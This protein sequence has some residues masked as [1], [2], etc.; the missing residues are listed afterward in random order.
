MPRAE[1]PYKVLGN[2]VA[3]VEALHALTTVDAVAD[4]LAQAAGAYGVE[5]FIATG[6]PMKGQ[7]FS[8]LVLSTRWPAAFFARYVGSHYARSDPLLRRS[9]Q[10]GLPFE[11]KADSYMPGHEV[12]RARAEHGLEH[13]Y[14]APIHHP[15]GYEGCVSMSGRALDLSVEAKLSLHILALY[16]FDRMRSLHP[17]L[18][19]DTPALTVRERE[20][21]SWMASGKSAA[22][23]SQSLK[24]SK[25]TVD[26]HSQSAARKLGAANR[27]QAV[28]MALRDGLIKV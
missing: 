8:D 9:I 5:H 21:L 3:F 14:L 2:A 24:I 6:I 26:E 4:A 16:A 17:G 12:M 13:G 23:V 7:P 28:V 1:E 27:T 10:S 25:R 11:W 18:A 15:D 22:Q 19:A 20:V